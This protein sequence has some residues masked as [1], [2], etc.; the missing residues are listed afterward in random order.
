[1]QNTPRFRNRADA[2]RKLAEAIGSRSD[3]PVVLGLP[4]GGVPVAFELARCLH[5]P[6]D[7]LLVRKIGA[8]GYPE[9]AIG[10][11]V[12]GQNPQRVMNEDVFA[13]C[14][15]SLDY[16]EKE[17]TRQLEEIERR[18]KIYLG[19]RPPTDLANRSVILVD[20][21]IAT[22]ASVKVALKALRQAEAG[23]VTLAVPVAPWMVIEDLKAE[24]DEVFCLSAPEDLQAV[25]L[26]YDHFDQTSDSEVTA[27]LAAAAEYGDVPKS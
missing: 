8:P 2:G 1:M 26:H 9:Y 10:A 27:L 18:R 6:L 4:R 5:A 3:D 23:H 7:I 21:G 16:F 22:G 14:G 25:S 13:F 11:V 19:D 12:D 24:V 20:D 17:A 15:A